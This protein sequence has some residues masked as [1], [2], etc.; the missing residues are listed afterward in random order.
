VAVGRVTPKLAFQQRRTLRREKRGFEESKEVCRN[1]KGY[2]RT[3]IC[4]WQPGITALVKALV[5]VLRPIILRQVNSWAMIR[6]I[7]SC[8]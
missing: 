6:L 7:V 5:N 3:N 8:Y 2:L 1:D 4:A